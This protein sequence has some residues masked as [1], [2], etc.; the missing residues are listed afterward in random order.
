MTNEQIQ[1]RLTEIG[2]LM[3]QPNADVEKLSKEIDQL[4]GT[5]LPEEDKHLGSS[6]ERSRGRR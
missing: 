1:K 2:N 3:K 6:W 5:S 4:L